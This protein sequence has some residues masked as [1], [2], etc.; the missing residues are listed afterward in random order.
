MKNGNVSVESSPIQFSRHEKGDFP[1]RK[2]IKGQDD[3]KGDPLPARLTQ[4]WGDG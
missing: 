2:K 1:A 4:N 3:E